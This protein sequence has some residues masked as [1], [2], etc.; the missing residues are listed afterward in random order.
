METSNNPSTADALLQ[1]V[2]VCTGNICRSPMGEVIYRDFLEQAGLDSQVAVASCGIGGWHVGQQADERALAELT[3]AGYDGSAHRAQQLN[4]TLADADLLVALDAGH[5][6]Q[7]RARG[8]PQERIRLARSFDPAS[9]P[10]ADVDDPYYGTAD[11]FQ[12]VRQQLEAAMPG[13]VDW[14]RSWIADASGR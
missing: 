10:Q 14:A 7:L 4:D 9:P 5:V 8:I 13:L 1:V 6:R 12:Q 2:F 11:D 3:Q